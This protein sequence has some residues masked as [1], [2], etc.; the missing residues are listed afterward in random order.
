MRLESHIIVFETLVIDFLENKADALFFIVCWDDDVYDQGVRDI[1]IK[2]SLFLW[3]AKTSNPLFQYDLQ[4]N[5]IKELNT[6]NEPIKNT[7]TIN[8]KIYENIYYSKVKID[9]EYVLIK[10]EI[11]QGKIL[12]LYDRDDFTFGEVIDI[13]TIRLL[14]CFKCSENHS[15]YNDH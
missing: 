5:F 12:S 4:G 14:P 15:M 6:N 13:K 10:K 11:Y 1:K 8:K 2:N 7:I 3:S 9:N